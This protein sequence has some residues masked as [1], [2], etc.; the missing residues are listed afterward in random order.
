[1]EKKPL[2]G[3]FLLLL[4]LVIPLTLAVPITEC[5]NITVS[6]TYELNADVTGNDFWEDSD[7]LGQQSTQCIRITVDDVEINGNGFTLDTPASDGIVVIGGVQNILIHNI[8]I[9]PD[10][11]GNGP[12]QSD[13][14][15]LTVTD[16]VLDGST[17]DTLFLQV[18]GTSSFDDVSGESG[19]VGFS[20]SSDATLTGTD[21]N[22]IA[23]TIIE[24]QG[25]AGDVIDFD[26]SYIEGTWQYDGS[27]G[28]SITITNTTLNGSFTSSNDIT[29]G[30][31]VHNTYVNPAGTGFS[32]TCINTSG[33]C[34]TPY[35]L[36]NEAAG[37]T[38]TDSQAVALTAANTAPTLNTVT[39]SPTANNQTLIASANATDTEGNNVTYFWRLFR[40]N[41]LISSGSNGTFPQGVLRNF[42]NFSTSSV[43]G[44]YIVE[45]FANDGLL[46][47]TRT[48]S[49]PVIVTF[50]GVLNTAPT[51]NTVTLTATANNQTLI[52]SAN[53]SDTQGNNVTYF[54]NLYRN[55]TNIASGSNGP[56]TQGVTVNFNNFSTG[57]MDG[58]YI[59]EVRASDGL[60]NSS[61]T[62]SS[63]VTVTFPGVLN[64]PPTLVTVTLGVTANNQTLIGSANATDAQ[65]NSITY[66]WRLF[67]NSTLINSGSNSGFP[68]GILRNFNNFST[69]SVDGTYILEAMANDGFL[70]SSRINSSPVTVTFPSTPPP[71]PTD[72]SD[73]DEAMG[74]IFI[75]FILIIL[76]LMLRQQVEAVQDFDKYFI[77]LI[78]LIMII[79][80]LRLLI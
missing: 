52:A 61:P 68:Q 45:V 1:M 3:I 70:N 60:L 30:A 49:T 10:S 50:P 17:T 44:T 77:G 57:S 65:N 79:A 53:A 62:N 12:L 56:F 67:R 41:T 75:L 59:V 11:G 69:S 5:Q 58:T 15:D 19:N 43:D 66:F 29:N 47:S 78:V 54:W 35:L 7:V 48:N 71:A 80:L 51:I 37:S 39:L 28:A 24:N 63:A 27:Q 38:L 21:L 76:Y 26:L 8:T 14:I 46:N 40:N 13:S 18:G 16:T 34:S 55:N 23:P 22:I 72:N 42:N 4:V 32:Q 36:S 20:I 73:V 31:L 2:L 6:D 25:D 64:T 9:F 33:I 74:T